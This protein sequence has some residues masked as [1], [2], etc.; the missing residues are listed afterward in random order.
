VIHSWEGNPTDSSL[1]K[2]Y[3]TCVEYLE[4]D[5]YTSGKFFP[6]F[7]FCIRFWNVCFGVTVMDDGYS[8]HK[9]V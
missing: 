5:P 2:A 3:K 1:D 6:H 8:L 4:I 7:N 9:R